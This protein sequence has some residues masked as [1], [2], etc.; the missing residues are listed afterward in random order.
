MWKLFLLHVD[1]K[2]KLDW[3]MR[4]SSNFVRLFALFLKQLNKSLSFSM[5][6]RNFSCVLSLSLSSANKFSSSSSSSLPLSTDTTWLLSSAIFSLAKVQR[7]ITI[8]VSKQL[9]A[10]LRCYLHHLHHYTI[11]FLLSSLFE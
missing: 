3:G 10:R 11:S 8:I 1:G 6:I 2:T 7:Q 9:P 4:R 5:K